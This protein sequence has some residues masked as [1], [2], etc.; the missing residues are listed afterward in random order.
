VRQRELKLAK[1]GPFFNLNCA[2]CGKLLYEGSDCIAYNRQPYC[3]K[4]CAKNGPA[5]LD[6]NR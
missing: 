4:T 2:W 5:P 1:V 3:D 6:N